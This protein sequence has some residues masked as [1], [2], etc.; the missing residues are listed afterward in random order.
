MLI[1]NKHDDSEKVRMASHIT[2]EDLNEKIRE[3]N[4]K[5]NNTPEVTAPLTPAEEKLNQEGI[6]PKNCTLKQLSQ[7]S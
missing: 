1:L 5:N 4:Q 3:Q 7:K 2:F 6:D